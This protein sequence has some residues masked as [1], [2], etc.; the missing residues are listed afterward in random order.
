[1]EI[2]SSIKSGQTQKQTNCLD[3]DGVKNLLVID[4]QKTNYSLA[5]AD[6]CR[7]KTLVVFY[8]NLRHDSTTI[9]NPIREVATSALIDQHYL[10]R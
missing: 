6:L 7:L 1:M 2:V 5:Y 8:L 10:V 9:P 3:T 4:N